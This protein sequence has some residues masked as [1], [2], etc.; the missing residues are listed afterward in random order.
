MM[1]FGVVMMVET[2]EVEE[3]V[4]LVCFIIT[5]VITGYFIIIR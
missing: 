4:M 1:I 2:A 3:R 5:I